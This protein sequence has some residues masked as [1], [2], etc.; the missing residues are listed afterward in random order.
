MAARNILLDSGLE[1]RVSDFGFSRVVGE[2][3]QG[4]TQSNVGPIKW[5]PPG[6]LTKKEKT[7]QAIPAADFSSIQESIRDREYSE[8]SDVWAYGVTLCEMVSGQEPYPGR[9]LL[10]IATQIR[11]NAL[12]PAAQIPAG[13]P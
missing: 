7:P 10:E 11:D 1:P 13:L 6:P 4:K 2:E 12:N 9:D 8:K 5:M 3:G